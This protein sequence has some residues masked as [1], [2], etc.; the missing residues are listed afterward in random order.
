MKQKLT[1]GFQTVVQWFQQNCL[2]VNIKKMF[3]GRKKRHSEIEHLCV[4]HDGRTLRNKQTPRYL[5]V[6]LDDKLCWEQHIDSV[7]K[8]D[9][10]SLAALRSEE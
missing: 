6:F 10:R 1:V 3:L 8:E 2:T 4:E 7:S 5:G 9:S